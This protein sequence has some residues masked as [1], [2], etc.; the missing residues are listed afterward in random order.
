MHPGQGIDYANVE[1]RPRERKANVLGICP[2]IRDPARWQSV[3]A[4]SQGTEVINATAPEV[5]TIDDRPSEE[6]GRV[7]SA[8]MSFKDYYV[9]TIIR[10][11]ETFDALMADDRRLRY[12]I[13]ALAINAQL[14]TLVY[15]FLSLGGAVPVSMKPWL[16]IPAAS[17]Y[18]FNEFLLAPSMFI[19]WILGAGVAQLLSRATSGKGSFEDMLGVL[20]FGISIACLPCCW[21]IFPS[22]FLAQSARSIRARSRRP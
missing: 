8:L 9:G 20:G 14:Y 6:G 17:Y 10:P 5:E 7:T 21:W 18:H 2:P 4:V 1:V 13:I 15:V 16:A 19:C 11:R 22:A 3:A 12:G